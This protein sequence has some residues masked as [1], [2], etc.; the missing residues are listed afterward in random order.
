MLGH[1]KHF[2]SHIF[3]KRQEILL[4]SSGLQNLPPPHSPC[5]SLLPARFESHSRQNC[6]KAILHSLSHTT[7]ECHMRHISSHIT[8]ANH[9]KCM[10]KRVNFE[11]NNKHVIPM[12]SSNSQKPRKVRIYIYTLYFGNN[13]A[14][15]IQRKPVLFSQ[16]RRRKIYV[17]HNEYQY[18]LESRRLLKY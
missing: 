2:E 4:L 7:F 1:K 5:L 14:F 13:V 17:L 12:E 6:R 9:M 15:R 16:P 3:R 11:S 8:L 10:L 18:R